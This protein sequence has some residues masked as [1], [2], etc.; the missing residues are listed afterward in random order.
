MEDKFIYAGTGSSFP[1]QITFDKNKR[2]F[3]STN[4]T[5]PKAEASNNF[6]NE[7]IQNQNNPLTNNL[8]SF[9]PLITNMLP[10]NSATNPLVST[11]LSGKQPSPTDLIGSFLNQNNNKEKEMVKASPLPNQKLNLDNI[12]TVEEYYNQDN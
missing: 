4:S 9:L 2:V 7:S 5:T 6:N 10:K 8:S 12:K 11:L 1:E 3:T